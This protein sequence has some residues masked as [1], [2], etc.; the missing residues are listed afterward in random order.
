MNPSRLGILGGR[1][2]QRP[3][4][5][6]GTEPTRPVSLDRLAADHSITQTEMGSP[7]DRF[8][9]TVG[10]ELDAVQLPDFDLMNS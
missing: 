5:P 7:R 9:A 8:S 1:G 10:I 2:P 6:F 3:S 4:P